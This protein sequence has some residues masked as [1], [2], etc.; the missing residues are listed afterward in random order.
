MTQQNMTNYIEEYRAQKLLINNNPALL[1]I[2]FK[3]T[4]I[5]RSITGFLN[6]QVFNW[7]NASVSKGWSL[8]SILSK[9]R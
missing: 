3:P 6:T 5:G 9:Q 8:Y 4:G 1:C 7:F 2:Y